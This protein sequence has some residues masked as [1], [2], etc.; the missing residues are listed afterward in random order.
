[1]FNMKKMIQ[2]M[3]LAFA[4]KVIQLNLALLGFISAGLAFSTDSDAQTFADVK[5]SIVN[6]IIIP[7]IDGI[8][9]VCILG[10]GAAVAVG[11]MNAYKKSGDE[12]G[13]VEAKSI[14]VPLIIGGCLLSIGFIVSTMTNS[15]GGTSTVGAGASGNAGNSF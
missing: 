7:S 14:F 3:K 13:R 1:M 4:E 11:L 10:G 15:V 8:K 2:K 6:N 5:T 12:G 9:W